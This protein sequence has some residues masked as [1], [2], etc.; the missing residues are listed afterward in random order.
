MARVLG[1]L[2]VVLAAGDG[3]RGASEGYPV[4]SGELP[5]G[6][7]FKFVKKFVSFLFLRYVR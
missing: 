7:I 5:F 2:L 4:S 3:N 1:W 6:G